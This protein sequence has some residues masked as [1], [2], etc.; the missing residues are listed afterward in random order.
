MTALLGLRSLVKVS[1][2]HVRVS[3]RQTWMK[4]E[5]KLPEEKLQ[6]SLPSD[7]AVA[8]STLETG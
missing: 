2:G 6:C 7:W 3:V 4:I 1:T 5:A 8:S